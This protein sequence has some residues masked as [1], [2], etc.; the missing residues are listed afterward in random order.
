MLSIDQP[1]GF[2]DL[3][4]VAEPARGFGGGLLWR[5]S[6]G[7]QFLTPLVQVGL[8]LVVDVA[9]DLGRP[10]TA[11]RTETVPVLSHATPALA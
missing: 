3:L 2:G 5:E 9:H 1:A 4:A 7:G 8:N 10:G 11:I 6:R